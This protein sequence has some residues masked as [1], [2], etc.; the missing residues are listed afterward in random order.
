MSGTWRDTKSAGD[1]VVDDRDRALAVVERV[2]EFETEPLV[3]GH[4]VEHAGADRPAAGR[5]RSE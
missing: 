3:I 2:E 4:R 5:V 1:D